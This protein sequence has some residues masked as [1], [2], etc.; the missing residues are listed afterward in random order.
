MKTLN[1][2]K[3]WNR[4]LDNDVFTSI[5]RFNNPISPGQRVNITLDNKR[6]CCAIVQEAIV[7]EFRDIPLLTIITDVGANPEQSYK[8]LKEFGFDRDISTCKVI[9][10]V[11]ERA[12][13]PLLWRV[14]DTLHELKK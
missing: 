14:N 12:P 10:Y 9:L 13:Y 5:R 11:L 7:C 4:K 6:Y 3:N 1:F 2:A 8:I